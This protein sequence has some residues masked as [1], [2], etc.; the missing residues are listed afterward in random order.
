[1]R[2]FGVGFVLLLVVACGAGTEED[3]PTSVPVTTTRVVE[4]SGEYWQEQ[5]D[6]NTPVW[7][8]AYERCQKPEGRHDPQCAV[9]LYTA[10][11]R[12]LEE[13]AAMPFPEYPSKDLPA[14]DSEPSR[15][16][17]NETSEGPLD[18]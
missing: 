8:R 13:A 6:E 3:V 14:T 5:A 16:N 7:Q 10:L 11:I 12:S 18:R 9:V 15:A 4:F 1:M 17:S 2:F